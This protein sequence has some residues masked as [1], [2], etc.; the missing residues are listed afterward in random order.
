MDFLKRLFQRAPKI[1][2]VDIKRRFELHG[3]VG[4]G[5]MSKVWRATDTIGSKPVAVKVLNKPQLARTDARFKSMGLK[6][7]H[8]GEISLSLRHPNIV[9]TLEFGITTDDEEFLVME[10]VEGVSLS[11]LVETQSPQMKKNC[12]WYCIQLGE[13]LVAVHRAGYIHRDLCPRNVIV[14]NEG[15]VKLIDFGLVVPNTDPYKRPGNRTGTANYMAPELIK[16]QATDQRIDIFS[17]AVT[18]FE[19]FTRQLPW[20]SDNT[21]DSVLQHINAPPRE[22]QKLAPNLDA[23]VSE[24]IMKGLEK[25]PQDRWQTAREMVDALR[26]AARRLKAMPDEE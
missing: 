10:F 18:C 17:F 14:S 6:R 7:P 9:K 21:M 8:E 4:Q 23:D 16:R 26:S 1:E 3:R 19:M 20:D 5:S 15:V 13:A 25:S 2:R 24:I 22:I 11:F 12:L